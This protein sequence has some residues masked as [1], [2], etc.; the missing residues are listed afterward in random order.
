MKGHRT[1]SA[2]PFHGRCIIHLTGWPQPCGG[3]EWAQARFRGKGTVVEI[4]GLQLTQGTL[5][6]GPTETQGLGHPHQLSEPFPYTPPAS[7]ES[8]APLWFQ[9]A[10]CSDWSLIS[11]L[12][13]PAGQDRQPASVHL[14]TPGRGCWAS[15]VRA[16]PA[17]HPSF[18]KEICLF[19]CRLAA[20]LAFQGR[21]TQPWRPPEYA[22]PRALLPCYGGPEVGHRRPWKVGSTLLEPQCFC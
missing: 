12:A 21:L 20:S 8:Q 16:S 5:G 4:S 3:P 9:K 22:V 10:T 15:A 13:P 19:P 17:G 6:P 7:K 18:K 14:Q 2:Q 11:P 1:A